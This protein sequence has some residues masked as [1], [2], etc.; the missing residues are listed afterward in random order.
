M[1]KN[2]SVREFRKYAE[3]KNILS[4]WYITDSQPV[5]R[6]DNPSIYIKHR[7]K[8]DLA[9][10]VEE[11]GLVIFKQEDNQMEIRL[12]NTIEIAENQPELE[13]NQIL[14]KFFCS[15]LPSPATE[16]EVRVLAIC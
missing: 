4:Y 16:H 10:V 15:E 12:I 8:Y 14:I 1:N 11:Q 7:V 6:D 3:E 9:A 13:K 2:V 5:N